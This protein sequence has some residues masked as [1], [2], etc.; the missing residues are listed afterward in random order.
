MTD[1]PYAYLANTPNRLCKRDAMLDWFKTTGR[2]QPNS[3]TCD[4]CEAR[5]CCKLAYDPYNVD[6]DC[7]VDK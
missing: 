5:S 4:T 6:G 3:I 1:N 7:L 2:P